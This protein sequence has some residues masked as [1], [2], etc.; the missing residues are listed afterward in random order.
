MS[1]LG[2][3]LQIVAQRKSLH[4]RSSPNAG[5]RQHS[6]RVSNRRRRSA[7]FSSAMST[8]VDCQCQL[9]VAPGLTISLKSA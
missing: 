1:L 5:N 2:Q 4:V 7:A 9:P 8:M 3:S 6:A